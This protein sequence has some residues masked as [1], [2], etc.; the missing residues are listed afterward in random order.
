MSS[1]ISEAFDS[2]EAIDER[3][4]PDLEE[5]D[6]L[7][8]ETIKEYMKDFV[9]HE[10]EILNGNLDYFRTLSKYQLYKYMKGG[11]YESKYQWFS[12]VRIWLFRQDDE[13]AELRFWSCEHRMH[14][15]RQAIARLQREV[16]RRI[17]SVEN[18]WVKTN[19]VV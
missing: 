19:E 11:F 2:R 16:R 3:Y 14:R 4:I 17:L 1:V 18:E 7:N 15:C 12:C 5:F 10:D 8:A 6:F 9:N 13:D